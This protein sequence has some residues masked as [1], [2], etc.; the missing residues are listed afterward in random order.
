[1]SAY[2]QSSLGLC[3]HKSQPEVDGHGHVAANELHACVARKPSFAGLQ[4]LAPV[5]HL[6]TA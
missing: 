4:V 5:L 3:Q 2:D 1:M 6:L